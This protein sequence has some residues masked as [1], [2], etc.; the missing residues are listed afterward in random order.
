VGRLDSGPERSREGRLGA[1]VRGRRSGEVVENVYGQ[2]LG[3]LG[4]GDREIVDEI[5]GGLPAE[6]L[7]GLVNDIL[8]QK[9]G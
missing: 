6:A 9:L 7:L 8:R 4:L 2:R 3:R 1:D 5:G